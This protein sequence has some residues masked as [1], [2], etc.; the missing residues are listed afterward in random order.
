MLYNMSNP[1][2]TGRRVKLYVLNEE[3][4]WADHGTGHISTLYTDDYESQPNIEI[5][6]E[7]NG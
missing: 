2:T 1:P 6:S 4:Q 3:H 5:R 7:E